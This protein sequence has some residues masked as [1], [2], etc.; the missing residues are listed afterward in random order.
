M[1][2]IPCP[3]CGTRDEHEFAYAREAHIARPT[4]A[5]QLSDREW[6]DYLFMRKNPKGIH[7][8]RWMH[9]KGCRR[10]F[11]VARHTVT[12]EILASYEM[13]QSAP[14]LAQEGGR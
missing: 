12:H 9:A 11:N 3:Y 6:A 10:Y 1:L 8:E 13:G 7:Y 4:N 14:D 2:R 5:D